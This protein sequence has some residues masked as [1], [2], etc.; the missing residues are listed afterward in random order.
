MSVTHTIDRKTACRLL[1]VSLRTVDRYLSTGRLSHIKNKGRVWLSK[2]EIVDL[3]K[4]LTDTG[5]ASLWHDDNVD[6]ETD[7]TVITETIEVKET[8]RDRD[9]TQTDTAIYKNL[10]IETKDK[11]DQATFRIG[12]L[13]SQLTS[14]VPLLEY[15]KQQR[16]LQQTNDGY[17]QKLKETETVL[18]AK[19]DASEIKIK[20]KDKEIEAERFN[21]A[22]F[23]VI[24]FLILF[25]QPILWIVLK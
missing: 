15:Q 6:R 22:I 1:N 4:E 25:L 18:L 12:Q 8:P 21:K 24:L 3:Y 7:N 11:L 10:Y 9:E 23:A 2:E 20:R 19:I 16:L 13:E 17:K 14:M 5:T